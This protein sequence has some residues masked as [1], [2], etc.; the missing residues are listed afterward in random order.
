MNHY[1][2]ME[3]AHQ[4]NSKVN[5]ISDET[6]LS[7]K[8]QQCNITDVE[9]KLE[10]NKDPIKVNNN[11]NDTLLNQALG[12]KTGMQ[13]ETLSKLKV[14]VV[15]GPILLEEIGLD[16]KEKQTINLVWTF[17]EDWENNICNG[18]SWDKLQS[19][20]PLTKHILHIRIPAT[21]REHE[22]P[23]IPTN[24]IQQ[25]DTFQLLT[26]DTTGRKLKTMD[27]YIGHSDDNAFK[28]AVK[29]IV[30]AIQAFEHKTDVVSVTIPDKTDQKLYE[31][32][33]EETLP[34]QKISTSCPVPI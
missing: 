16:S 1:G 28:I 4:A 26:T 31:Q 18:D 6:D 21:Q 19:A 30:D 8:L 29:A 20:I 25:N 32:A 3:L 15:I 14:K 7:T 24:Y 5:T 33:L 23:C 34:N 10:N 11:K 12:K 13:N 9:H 2:E 22:M 27:L 17:V